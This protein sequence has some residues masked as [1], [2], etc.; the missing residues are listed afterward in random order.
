L[1]A[2]KDRLFS[3]IRDA[4]SYLVCVFTFRHHLLSLSLS[5]CRRPL[6]FRQQHSLYLLRRSLAR[7]VCSDVP[8]GLSRSPPPAVHALRIMLNFS[9]KKA[10]AAAGRPVA[11]ARRRKGPERTSTA[12]SSALSPR[13]LSHLRYPPRAHS[14]RRKSLSR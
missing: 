11:R 8:A 4:C 14:P 13:P 5:L 10:G 7:S 2:T 6:L 9:P 3:L 12:P 1:I